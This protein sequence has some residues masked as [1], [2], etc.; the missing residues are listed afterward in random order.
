MPTIALATGNN[1]TDQY[2]C[3]STTDIDFN[4]DKYGL[5]PVDLPVNKFWVPNNIYT[6]NMSTQPLNYT[7]ACVGWVWATGVQFWVPTDCSGSGIMRD[8]QPFPTL[9]SGFP[10]NVRLMMSDAHTSTHTR[11]HASQAFWMSNVGISDFWV[12]WLQVRGLA[13]DR[14]YDAV[15]VCSD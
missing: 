1:A 8:G 2:Q 13:G 3:N 10:F 7:G 15:R 5:R 4:G 11:C 14:I 12:K 6:W 9:A